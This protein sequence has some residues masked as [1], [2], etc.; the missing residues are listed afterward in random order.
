M[1]TSDIRSKTTAATA[2]RFGHTAERVWHL[3]HILHA[4]SSAAHWTIALSCKDIQERPAAARHAA[5]GALIPVLQRHALA[6]AGQGQGQGQGASVGA[7]DVRAGLDSRKAR[8]STA[9][10]EL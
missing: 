3:P 1:E 10:T 4:D 9:N 8:A 2:S 7:H 6:C 5:A